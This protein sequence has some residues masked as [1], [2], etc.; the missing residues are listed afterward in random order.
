[1]SRPLRV[2]VAGGWYHV[3]ARG[4]KRRKIFQDDR[5]H[6]HFLEL[7]DSM[8]ERFGIV[9]HTYVEFVFGLPV[10]CCRARLVVYGR[11]AY[12]FTDKRLSMK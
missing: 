4:I 9:L 1:M 3:T 11:T 5:E 6:E 12:S 10:S 8:V 2:D 7:L